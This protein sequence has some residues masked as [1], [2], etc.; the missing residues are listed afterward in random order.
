MVKYTPER[1]D[2]G[3]I[4]V[5]KARKH[6]EQARKLTTELENT[7]LRIKYAMI[8][9]MKNFLKADLARLTATSLKHLI[10]KSPEL[11]QNP[12]G[13]AKMR[14]KKIQMLKF[15]NVY[16]YR[17]DRYEDFIWTVLKCQSTDRDLMI[18]KGEI[19]NNV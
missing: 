12:K 17:F 14:A 16:P 4:L 9:D 13:I 11:Y 10:E 19:E 1:I 18:K 8:F 5:Q 7:Y 2:Q 6:Q 3:L 15:G